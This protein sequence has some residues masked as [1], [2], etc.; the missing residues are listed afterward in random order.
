M[1][2]QF[3]KWV[4]R[5]A[6][7]VF[8]SKI[9]FDNKDII[10]KGTPTILAINHP[11]AF[12]DPIFVATHISPKIYTMLRG[13]LFN[14]SFK[15]WL[16]DQIGTIPIFRFRDGFSGMR[17]NQDTFDRC[18]ELLN[19]NACISILSEGNMKHEK[20]L[21]PIQK[22]TAKMALGV[23][24]TYGNDRVQIIPVGV[25]YSDSNQFRSVLMAS[26]GTPIRIADYLD[27]HRENPRK[28]ILQITRE[29]QSQL[30]ER[31]IHIDNPE[32]DKWINQILDIHR[33][34]QLTNVLP[35]YVEN[36]TLLNQEL[37]LVKKMNN[38][39]PDNKKRVARETQDYSKLL[40]N[41]NLTDRGV[42]QPQHGHLKNTLLLML[43]FIPFC[44]GW[45]S[46][47]LPFY[48]GKKIATEKTRKIEF[49]SSVRLGTY[50]GVYLVQ[51]FVLLLLALIVNQ[52][53]FWMIILAT[54]IIGYFAV[55]YNDKL[56]LWREARA[57]PRGE[58]AALLSA[59]AELLKMVIA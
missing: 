29:I 47:F 51:Y 38:L 40:K 24:E 14:S 37:A 28:A 56:Q 58:R 4:T 1:I 34:N 57:V 55:L 39:S 19:Q 17:N 2:Y 10:K 15:I 59:R 16:L 20:R 13:D 44:W 5:I 53:L 41:K 33:N 25:N 30:S 54:P 48:F 3:V 11:T 27:A 22:G 45:L 12:I 46:N 21:R 42:V 31:V 7:R 52:W 35:T 50:L 9:F 43:G 23:Y 8:F 36:S 6:I 49:F 18:Y 26:V 32:D